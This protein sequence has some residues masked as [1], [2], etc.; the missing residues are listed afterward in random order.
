MLQNLF[1][2]ENAYFLTVIFPTKKKSKRFKFRW[3]KSEWKKFIF[4]PNNHEALHFATICFL[5]MGWWIPITKS[6]KKWKVFTHFFIHLTSFF[7]STPKDGK[8]KINFVGEN[9]F[10]INCISNSLFALNFYLKLVCQLTI[11]KMTA[12][13]WIKCKKWALR[14]KNF[15]IWR[16]WAR[17]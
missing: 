16:F 8:F 11:T 9:L 15:R 7:T 6:H 17:K 13:N 10:M 12:V 3:V 4:Q 14:M 2:S 5:N 1:P